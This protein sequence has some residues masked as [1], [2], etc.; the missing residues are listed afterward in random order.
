MSGV[1][2]AG[3]GD[4]GRNASLHS[5]NFL[6]QRGP[7][8]PSSLTSS[9]SRHFPSDSTPGHWAGETPIASFFSWRSR[10][11]PSSPDEPGSDPITGSQESGGDSLRIEETIRPPGHLYW[12]WDG[13]DSY[14]LIYAS[15]RWLEG[16]I[17]TTRVARPAQLKRKLLFLVTDATDGTAIDT[18]VGISSL[19]GYKCV[20]STDINGEYYIRNCSVVAVNPH[21]WVSGGSRYN[22]KWI[23]LEI[24]SSLQTINVALERKTQ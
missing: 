19:F 1:T 11:E 17:F 3:A 16:T 7:R 4:R 6:D 20:Q 18:T 2:V 13:A 24:T 5:L 10:P 12:R 8:L 9:N 14:S 15:S 23:D 22:D 21:L